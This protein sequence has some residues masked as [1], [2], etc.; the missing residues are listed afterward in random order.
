MTPYGVEQGLRQ[1]MVTQVIQDHN[2]LIWMTTGDGLHCFDGRTFRVFRVPANSGYTHS[3]NVMRNVAE[4][5]RELLTLSSSS[6]LLRFNTSTG[7][8]NTIFREDGSYPVLFDQRV[9]N[10]PAAWIN[11]LK[12]CLIEAE[13]VVPKTLRFN[14]ANKIPTNLSPLTAVSFYGKELLLCCDEGLII[15]HTNHTASGS[16]FDATWMPVNG[17]QSAASDNHGKIYILASGTLFQYLGAGKLKKMVET[18]LRDKRDL[19]I[20]S[21]NNFWLTS[22]VKTDQY[23]LSDHILFEMKFN[24]YEGKKLETLT[25]RI[26]SVYEDNHHNLWL[27]TDGDGV[28][29]YA[30]NQVHFLRTDLGFTRC[31][32]WFGNALWAGTYHNG[33]WRVSQGLDTAH[34][35]GALNDSDVYYLDLKVDNRNRLWAA[36]RQGL[37]VLDHQGKTLLTH[38]FNC[39]SAKLL[40]LSNDTVVCFCNHQMYLYHSGNEPACI[41]SG[42]FIPVLC[43]LETDNGWWIGNQYGLYRVPKIDGFNKGGVFTEK[44]QVSSNAVY[45]LIMHQGQIWAATG[46]GIQIFN[47]DGTIST[48][49]HSIKEIHNEVIYALLP[50]DV[51][52]VWFSGNQGLGCFN[53]KQDFIVPFN[54]RNNLQSLE[55]NYN[56]ACKAPNGMLYFGGIRGINGFDPTWFRAK[57]EDQ[58]VRLISLSVS[59][60]SFSE[61]I[62]PLNATIPLSRK[63]PHISGM[64]FCSDYTYAGSQAFSFFLEGYQKDWGKPSLD[65][66]FNYRDLPP[67]KYRLWVKYADTWQNWSNPVALITVALHPPFWKT[68]W[69]QLILF[70]TVIIITS[71]VVRRINTIRYARRIRSLEQQNAVEKERLRI[72]KDMH[73]DLGASLTR[74]SILSEL[75]KKQNLDPVKYRQI[76]EQIS[77]IS[78][79]VVDDMSE[80]IWAMNPRN[81]TLDSFSSHIRQYASSFLESAAI[82]GHFIFPDLVPARPMSSELRRNLFLTIKEALNNIVKHS[83]TKEVNIKL[84]LEDQM[85]RMMITDHG[86]GFTIEKTEGRGNGLINMRKR[87]E[88][89]GGSFDISSEIGKGT[90]IRISVQLP[91]TEM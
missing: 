13:K 21:K 80:I 84:I 30:P 16:G 79:G 83:G 6:S 22:R 48:L 15:I 77:D 25:P 12:F 38:E 52:Q 42:K 90:T 17:Y 68:I 91:V 65:A 47:R 1:S 66:S 89:H 87:I 32:T 24:Y 10:K 55:F 43:Y 56:A 4:T 86:T 33:L 11:E 64:V 69:F 78:G 88:E 35:M 44:K 51:G 9:Q 82:H 76:I 34:R 26:I 50:D 81:D 54:T 53:L 45:A 36:S 14:R 7:K 46:N 27:G 5:N 18:S 37:K 39:Q 28:L 40:I 59:D 73:D 57:K 62:P 70:F 61:G 75:A 41:S 67:G 72:S 49:P 31:L 29:L 58:P 60:T 63:A 85:L 19:F 2:G 23:K 20:D 74:I 8:F 71:L 3:D